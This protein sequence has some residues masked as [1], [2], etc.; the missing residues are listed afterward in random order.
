MEVFNYYNPNPTARTDSKTGKPKR[1][2]K[3]DCVI[4]AFCC[5]LN[6][7]WDD[8]FSEMCKIA[9]KVHDMP[10]SHSVIDRYAKA[11]GMIKVSI[12]YYT[13]IK[14]FAYDHNGVY[15]IN[16][17]GHIT[18]VHNNQINDCWDCGSYKMKTYYTVKY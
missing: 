7:S 11:N 2:S 13:T 17:R 15:V 4:R 1:W 8:V 6:K 9:A 5:A 12:P 14:E 18:C 3:G 16:I 10:N